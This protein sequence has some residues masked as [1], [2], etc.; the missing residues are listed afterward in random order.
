MIMIHQPQISLVRI[1][2]E[3]EFTQMLATITVFGSSFLGEIFLEISIETFLIFKV[4][5]LSYS[6]QMVLQSNFHL[7]RAQLLKQSRMATQI[8]FMEDSR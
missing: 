5:Q 3:I 4:D 1:S 8:S 2:I 6:S 7:Q